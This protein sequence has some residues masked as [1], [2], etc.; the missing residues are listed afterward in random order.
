MNQN[1]FDDLRKL[2]VT[3]EPPALGP[4]RR[5]HT[6]SLEAVNQKLDSQ[7]GSLSA[8][9]QEAIR[10]A[11]LLWHDHLEASHT[12]SQNIP[13][14]DGSFLHGIMHRREPDYGNSRYWFRQ[15][16]KHAIFPA[17]AQRVA[18]FLKSKNAP[19]LE[20]RLLPGGEWN[21]CVFVDVCEE[22]AELAHT[23]LQYQLLR[24][25]QAIEFEVLLEY[26]C[27]KEK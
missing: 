2:I 7:L 16:G 4:Q 22:T 9:R 15:V 5:P 10:S 1:E 8:R 13:G 21:A 3:P 17:L 24:G 11:I 20:S 14:A 25:V 23:H 26:L 12:I 18:N 19:A 6:D 27:A